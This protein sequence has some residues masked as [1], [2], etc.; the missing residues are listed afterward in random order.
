MDEFLTSSESLFDKGILWTWDFFSS[1]KFSTSIFNILP[2]GPDPLSEIKS[3][4]LCF[5]IL[6]AKGETNILVSFFLNS[7]FNA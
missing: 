6:F 2:L 5:V 3:I 7:R 4:S 1:L